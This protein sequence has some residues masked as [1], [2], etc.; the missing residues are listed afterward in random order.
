[1]RAAS[2][3]VAAPMWRDVHAELKRTSLTET[4]VVAEQVLLLPKAEKLRIW[5]LLG[6]ASMLDYME[7]ELGLT[8]RPAIERLR[9]GRALTALPQIAAEFGKG[10]LA[11]SVVRELTRVVVP[12]TEARWLEAARDKLPKQVEEMVSGRKPG[13]LPDTPKDPDLVLRTVTLRLTPPKVALLREIQA[14]ARRELGPDTSD[15]DVIELVWRR[16]GAADAGSDRPAYQMSIQT[17]D[18]CQ[19]ATQDAAGVRVDVDP[20]TLACAECDHESI[21][22]VTDEA[23]PPR[24]SKVSPRRRAQVLARDQR[25]CVVPGCRS[26][27]YLDVHHVVFQSRGGT[28]KLSN[29]VT[30]CAGH[31]CAPSPGRSRSPQ[32][33]K[34]ACPSREPPERLAVTHRQN[35]TRTLDDSHAGDQRADLAA[36]KV[37]N[38]AAADVLLDGHAQC[39]QRPGKSTCAPSKLRACR[40]DDPVSARADGERWRDEHHVTGRP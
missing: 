13:D 35:A 6:H 38:P 32:G 18:Q 10:A 21:G 29:L 26:A 23:A 12:Q 24:T 17:C 39:M 1:M 28:N 14:I 5:E 19:R 9:M 40:R 33:R 22:D 37:I 8:P 25:R 4:M 27:S 2:S 31:G 20:V 15:D 16:F 30:L 3:G 11:Y 36:A 7:R 34:Q